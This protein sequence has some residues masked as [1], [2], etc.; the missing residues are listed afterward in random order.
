M[1]IVL[2]KKNSEVYE[3]TYSISRFFGG[4]LITIL[5]NIM[6]AILHLWKTP[7]GFYNMCF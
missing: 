3:S 2:F 7:G 6:I 5:I 4:M 1:T